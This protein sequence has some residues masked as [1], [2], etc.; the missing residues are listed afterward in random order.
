[1]SQIIICP[2]VFFICFY[3][4]LVTAPSFVCFTFY[5]NLETD[6]VISN[7]E[8]V[9]SSVREFSIKNDQRAESTFFL[10]TEPFFT[11]NTAAIFVPFGNSICSGEFTLQYN[12]ITQLEF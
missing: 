1:M 5:F 6:A 11:P 12:V 7:V 9:L 8:E 4:I 10:F 3:C 2:F